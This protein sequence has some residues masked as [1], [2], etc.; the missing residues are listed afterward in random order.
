MT[1]DM[2]SVVALVRV[3][4]TSRGIR[5]RPP[6]DAEKLSLLEHSIGGQLSDCARALY[7]Q[8]DGFAED[9]PDH[10]TMLRLWSTDAIRSSLG[11]ESNLAGQVIADHFIN[12]DF[13]IC[14][15]RNH[16]SP[17]WWQERGT[18]AAPTLV[19]F[20]LRLADGTFSP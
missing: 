13:L 2:V 4:L 16:N 1:G 10:V 5:L 7:E 19:D 14:D 20:C 8:F 3:G 15:L 17:V 6:A 18:T 11:C 12:A 9:V